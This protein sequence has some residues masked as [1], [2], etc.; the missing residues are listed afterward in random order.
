MLPNDADMPVMF[1]N[2]ATHD[3]RWRIGWVAF[4]CDLSRVVDRSIARLLTPPPVASRTAT[5]IALAASVTSRAGE[6]W[7]TT[8]S[9]TAG[10][11]GRGCGGL[12]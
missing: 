5:D 1:Y 11:R 12:E 8:R 2:G 9:K 10:C 6:I 4:S 3:A 7:L